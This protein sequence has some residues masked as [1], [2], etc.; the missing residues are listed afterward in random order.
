MLLGLALL[1]YWCALYSSKI[2][3]LYL[4]C[5]LK[6]QD[7]VDVAPVVLPHYF[8]LL[9]ARLTELNTFQQSWNNGNKTDRVSS[10]ESFLVQ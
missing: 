5:I 10:E 3:K 8:I 4:W 1:N 6:S 9:V 2:T 7:P